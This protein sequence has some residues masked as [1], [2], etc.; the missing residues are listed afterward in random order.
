MTQKDGVYKLKKT[1]K[2]FIP[3]YTCGFFLLI[4]FFVAIK[5]EVNLPNIGKSFVLAMSL[6]AFSSAEL[7]RIL[8]KYRITPEKVIITHG[9]IKKH[10]TNVH[11]HPL[12]F[13]PDINVHQN[14]IQRILSYGTVFIQG[15]QVNQLEIKDIDNP[16]KIMKVIEEHIDV[17]RGPSSKRKKE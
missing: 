11:F 2:A 8:V 16:H 12:G 9:I 1:R 7:S 6:L 15:G 14:F 3:E 5:G 13:A 4:L 17:N 10:I